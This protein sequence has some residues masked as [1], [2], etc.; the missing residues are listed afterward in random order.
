[1]QEG[2]LDAMTAE[3]IRAHL[4]VCYLCAKEYDEMEQTVRLI[5]TLP[6]VEPAR[7]YAP[8]IMAALKRQPDSFFQAPMAEM[9]TEAI[10]LLSEPRSVT[11]PRKRRFSLA[12]FQFWKN[13]QS[14][15][16]LDDD[17][18]SPTDRGILGSFLALALMGLTMS[19]WGK[20]A[21]ASTGYG[22][23]HAFEP[24]KSIP[25]LNAIASYG[26]ASMQSAGEA[27]ALTLRSATGQLVPT[28]AVNAA[29]ACVAGWWL[30]RRA[31][32]RA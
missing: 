16:K 9:E 5:E 2:L 3:A 11:G 13:R 27:M 4:S 20:A 28:L 31:A 18:I 21:F 32:A 7:S 23:G 24:L 22:V 6:F 15:S 8:S 25:A 19:S 12:D 29:F 26:M 1:M 10:D 14:T 30:F 17:S